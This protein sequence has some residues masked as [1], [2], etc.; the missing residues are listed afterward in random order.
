[1][2]NKKADEIK[3]IDVEGARF[4]ALFTPENRKPPEMVRPEAELI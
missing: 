3:D 4:G 2:V 1:M